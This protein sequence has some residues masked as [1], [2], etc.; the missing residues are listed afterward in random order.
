MNLNQTQ[1]INK[2]H[3]SQEVPETYTSHKLPA[4]SSQVT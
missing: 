3:K 4:P 1:D 2:V